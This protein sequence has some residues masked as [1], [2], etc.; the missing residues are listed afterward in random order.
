L[1]IFNHPIVRC[2]AE[3]NAIALEPSLALRKGLGCEEKHSLAASVE[4]K[5]SLKVGLGLRLLLANELDWLYGVGVRVR[6]FAGR[7]D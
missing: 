1:H 7:W 5:K 4:E 2:P 3:A 6:G